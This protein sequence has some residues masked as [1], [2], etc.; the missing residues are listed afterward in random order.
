MPT[1][2]YDLSIEQPVATY[3]KSQDW[4]ATFYER[5]SKIA[6]WVTM[7]TGMCYPYAPKQVRIAIV[8]YASYV[9]I[10]DD[11]GGEFI[12][13]LGTFQT[14]LVLGQQQEHPILQSLVD[15]HP[16][17]KEC[18][19]PYAC[20]MILKGTI[21]FISGCILELRYD[22]KLIP[23]QSAPNFPQ[24]L[25]LKTGISEPHAHFVFPEPMYPEGLCLQTYLPV[26]PDLVDFI[27]YANDIMSFYKESVVSTEQFNF[28]SNYSRVHNTAPL[29]VLPIIC[30]KTIQCLHRIRETLSLSADSRMLETTEEF[31]QGYLAWYLNRPRYKL[32]DFD[33]YDSDG[34]KIVPRRFPGE[35]DKL[36]P[37]GLQGP[38]TVSG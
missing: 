21:E 29:Q 9:M 24:Y 26:M 7:G 11:M 10:I 16:T 32:D 25:R 31:I 33:I 8:I 13:A 36:V 30:E 5:A 20:D 35:V 12:D 1:V 37:S 28:I 14:R 18:F 3:I 4:P 15:F 34:V 27:N 19:G 23:P 2:E 38:V 6:R 22:G 17:L